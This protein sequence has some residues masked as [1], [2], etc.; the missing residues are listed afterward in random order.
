MTQ[1]VSHAPGGSHAQTY[2]GPVRGGHAYGAFSRTG[3]MGSD[4]YV[5]SGQPLTPMQK[6]ARLAALSI[7]AVGGL[8]AGRRFLAN[9]RATQA[10]MEALK[11]DAE[12]L[13]FT[14]K[15]PRK[16]GKS[17]E[18]M[19]ELKKL[20]RQQGQTFHPDKASASAQRLNTSGRQA[21]EDYAHERMSEFNLA[22]GRLK[23]AFDPS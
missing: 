22:Y 9:R 7:A 15:M 14:G 13:G 2:S 4:A 3:Q 16:P 5:G 21:V 23:K 1:Q 19:A 11:K 12:L 20:Y 18:F 6:L 17:P 8:F 10:M